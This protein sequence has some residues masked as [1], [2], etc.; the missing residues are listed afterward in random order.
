MDGPVLTR[1]D[2]LAEE[3]ME[4]AKEGRSDFEEEDSGADELELSRSGSPAN[5]L[6]RK[7]VPT[8]G[9]WGAGAGLRDEGRYGSNRLARQL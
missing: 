8:F 3:R 9:G 2:P 4:G 1:S 5:V 6:T 7:V